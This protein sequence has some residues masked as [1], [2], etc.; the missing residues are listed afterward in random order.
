MD[1]QTV[2]LGQLPLETDSLKQ[3]RNT[4]VGLAKLAH[5][6][7]GDG[8]WVSGLSCGPTSPGSLAVV[9]S[10]GEI[11]A[12]A[13]IDATSYSSLAADSR[14]IL[15]QGVL[16]DALTLTLSAP[17][18]AGYSQA[19]LIQVAFAETDGGSTVLP[20]YNSADPSHAWS[21]PGNSGAAQYT[22][23]QDKAVVAAKAGI[24]AAT[25]SQVAPQ[26]DAGNV[27]L[28]VVTVANG[29][30]AVTSG[31]ISMATAAPFIPY[32]L[33]ELGQ[34]GVADNRVNFVAPATAL[35]VAT[36]RTYFVDSSAAAR[37]ITLPSPNPLDARP[38]TIIRRGT[39]PV[40]VLRSS[41]AHTIEG[42]ADD[43]VM[44]VDFMI[45]VFAPNSASNFKVLNRRK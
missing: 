32:T 8:P 18:T 35:L 31:N 33:P 19:W 38:I 36:G 42:V 7:L 4:L 25:G 3:S 23:R 43:V 15:K 20:Y 45:L 29:A 22:T 34:M 11:Y 10:P 44:D 37:S 17:S 21:G 16:M 5:G 39:Y 27:A 9:I 14:Q 13:A 28:W 40:T 24:A 12:M 1:R 30:T 26:P 6:V 41:S 2:Y